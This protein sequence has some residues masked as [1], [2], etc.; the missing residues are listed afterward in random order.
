MS[1]NIEPISP[2]V[3]CCQKVI[4]LAFDESMSYYETLCALVKYLKDTVIPAVN[5]NADAVTELQ[6]KFNELKTY[7]DTYFEN[8]DVQEEINNKLDELVES[9][10][11]QRILNSPAT[12]ESLGGVIVK[13]GLQIDETGNLSLQN[14][15][16][17]TIGG[18]IA[19]DGL[20]VDEGNL[21]AKAGSGITVDDNG[22]S[23]SPLYI[24]GVES[25]RTTFV[26]ETT[27]ANSIVNYA[28]IPAGNKPKFVMS[29]P[30]NADTKKKASE[31]D[32]KHKPTVMAN[33]SGWNTET[34][35]AYGVLI[36]DNVVKIE[37]NLDEGT[38]WNRPIIGIDANGKLHCINGSTPADEVNMP[39][40]CRAWQCIYND[41]DVN[42]SMAETKEPRTFIGQDYNGNYLIGVCGG[43][44]GDD[45]GMSL[46]DVLKFVRT[47][48]NFNAKLLF[49]L[50]G[51]GSS[52]LLVHG[53]RQNK[54]IAREDRACPNW[55]VWSTESTIDDGVY[56]SQSINNKNNINQEIDDSGSIIGYQDIASAMAGSDRITVNPPSRIIKINPR[57][58]AYT[59]NF[60]ITGDGNLPS[61][62]DLFT[63]LPRTDSNI[64]TTMLQ[65]S[66]YNQ[67][68]IYLKTE[69][70][71][72]RFRT[73]TALPAGEYSIQIVVSCDTQF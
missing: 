37:N 49:N 71:Y 44:K 41:G 54:L 38:Y 64:Y 42:P 24:D 47:T 70:G 11:L 65:H 51:G 61:Y 69:T 34:G 21:S 16:S 3:T 9:G 26:D 20:D 67:V 62:S 1:R 22:I 60:K 17:E 5:E 43:R 30:A 39:Y 31:F 33:L 29:D 73:I 4:P 27:G 23:I 66:G 56:E 28:I 12:T 59:L 55:V 52:N 32:Y 19:G 45:T 68:P 36:I 7:V 57:T 40:A 13:D 15:T 53:I 18:I 35:T 14:A 50:D 46:G 6:V 72:S 2:F 63:N 58:V 10:E 48:I 8:L 25:I